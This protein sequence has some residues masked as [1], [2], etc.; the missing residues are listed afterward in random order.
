MVGRLNRV[1]SEKWKLGLENGTSVVTS[2]K[3][4]ELI[5]LVPA[6]STFTLMTLHGQ[7][8]CCPLPVSGRTVH[9]LGN[10]RRKIKSHSVKKVMGSPRLVS[11]LQSLGLCAE[12]CGVLS[13]HFIG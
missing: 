1:I 11:S 9:N 12:K 5:S 3:K 7:R 2:E 13:P 6:T 4:N 8:E 10:C